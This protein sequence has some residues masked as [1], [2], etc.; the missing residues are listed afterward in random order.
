MP[1]GQPVV[2]RMTSTDV[3][4]SFG[5]IEYRLKE[6]ILPGRITHLWFYPDKPAGNASS[7]ASNSAA[8]ATPG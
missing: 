1:V 3:I 8:T 6:D 7:P 4:H 5:L 2:L